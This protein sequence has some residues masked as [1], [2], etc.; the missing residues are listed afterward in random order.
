MRV[1]LLSTA[2]MIR[3]VFVLLFF[4]SFS[5][6][7]FY[8]EV[9][10]DNNS[11]VISSGYTAFFA[12]AKG[13]I[14][15]DNKA[16]Q[17]FFSG[18][19]SMIYLY[20]GSDQDETNVVTLNEPAVSLEELESALINK[21]FAG[22]LRFET[23]NSATEVR[24]QC[25]RIYNLSTLQPVEGFPCTVI[26]N[27]ENQCSV[28]VSNIVLDHGTISKNEINDSPPIKESLNISCLEDTDTL[29]TMTNVDENGYL[30]LNDEGTIKSQLAVDGKS[31][32][33]GGAGVS[34][35]IPKVGRDITL[36][37]K[38]SSA[39]AIKENPVKKSLVMIITP[40]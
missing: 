40:V 32:G 12:A 29:V 8:I 3:A 17:P 21:Q 37:S 16:K 36:S 15:R 14:D 23:K 34:I 1:I 9:T 7:A 20:T 2:T 28:K 33:L 27:V 35:N 6:N 19:I 4:I 25:L 13:T 26:P 24:G 22:N 10:P 11:S 30:D 38:L 5:C 18:T 39:G 31:T